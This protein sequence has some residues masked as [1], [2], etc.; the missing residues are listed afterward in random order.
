MNIVNNT[1]SVLIS[2][3]VTFKQWDQNRV[4]KKCLIDI[5]ITTSIISDIIS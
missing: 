2:N 4:N 3:I 1:D 5:L